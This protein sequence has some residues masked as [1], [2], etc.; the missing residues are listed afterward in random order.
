MVMTIHGAITVSQYELGCCGGCGG[1][2][3]N[4][5]RGLSLEKDV[6]LKISSRL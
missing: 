3:R 6:G 2:R 4:T 5:L 1:L